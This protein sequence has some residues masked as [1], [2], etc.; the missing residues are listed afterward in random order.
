MI[1][2]NGTKCKIRFIYV[3]FNC[4]RKKWVK[5]CLK[6]TSIKG[7][8]SPTLNGKIHPKFP[9][10]LFDYLPN[11]RKT[12]HPINYNHFAG[13]AIAIN[14]EYYYLAIIVTK[15]MSSTRNVLTMAWCR[16]GSWNLVIESSFV[17]TESIRFGQDFEV[18]F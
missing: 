15:V 12:I 5:K 4:K 9:F 3:G 11:V 6:I 16:F 10:W 1:F 8:G 13:R 18:W 14:R 2:F 7:G 17:Q